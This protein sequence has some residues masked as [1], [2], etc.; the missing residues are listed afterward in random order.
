MQSYHSSTNGFSVTIITHH[1]KIKVKK[2]HSLNLSFV[3]EKKNPKLSLLFN[4][5]CWWEGKEQKQTGGRGQQGR[6]INQV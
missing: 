4:I 3:K 2:A 1:F 5:H 6:K